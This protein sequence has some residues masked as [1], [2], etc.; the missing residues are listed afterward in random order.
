MW[1]G[2]EATASEHWIRTGFLKKNKIKNKKNSKQQ[3]SA[4]SIH[5]YVRIKKGAAGEHWTRNLAFTS[6]MARLPLTATLTSHAC[7]L[8]GNDI[9]PLG[10]TAKLLSTKS[11]NKP[12]KFLREFFKN[13]Y[14]VSNK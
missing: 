9:T 3:D 6:P 8:Q 14:L 12:K 13:K 2:R 1:T 5:V 10:A 7:Y 4:H 11:L